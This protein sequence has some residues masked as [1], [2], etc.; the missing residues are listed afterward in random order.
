[1]KIYRYAK[2]Q[3]EIYHKRMQERLT[4]SSNVHKW[5]FTAFNRK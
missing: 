1:M 2:K 3:L 4:H 5:Y